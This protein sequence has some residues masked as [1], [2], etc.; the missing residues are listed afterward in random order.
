MLR[1]SVKTDGENQGSN[2]TE[3]KRGKQLFVVLRKK[4]LTILPI[5]L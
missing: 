4:D 5:L 2:K 3:K 1:C